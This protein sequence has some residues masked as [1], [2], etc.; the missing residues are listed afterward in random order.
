MG[1][2]QLLLH[3]LRKKIGV[4]SV[5]KKTCFCHCK[6]IFAIKVFSLLS[7]SYVY[8]HTSPH[9]VRKNV[10]GEKI[11]LSE[12]VLNENQ[13]IEPHLGIFY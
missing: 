4:L 2:K 12:I 3:L 5:Q 7:F 1:P 13:K 6:F 11:A 8:I 10:R 9:L